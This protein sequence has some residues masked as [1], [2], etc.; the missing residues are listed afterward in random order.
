MRGSSFTFLSDWP[1]PKF[2]ESVLN[3]WTKL[4]CVKSLVCPQHP[5]NI[6]FITGK[7]ISS[8][9]LQVV[10]LRFGSLFMMDRIILHWSPH[11]E[12]MKMLFLPI[13]LAWESMTSCSTIESLC[14][15]GFQLQGC[16]CKEK[17]GLLCIL[18]KGV[19]KAWGTGIFRKLSSVYEE[20]W[21]QS[22]S[23]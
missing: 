11:A 7:I 18:K 5:A 13:S 9:S 16:S 2:S 21:S 10:D 12:Q 14:C 17:R 3:A 15:L 8:T 20:Q 6:W 4:P 1:C 23:T 22:L 19:P